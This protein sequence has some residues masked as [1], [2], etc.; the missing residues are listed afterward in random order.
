MESVTR[1]AL[2]GQR[3]WQGK[4][5]ITTHMW[6]KWFVKLTRVPVEVRP[7]FKTYPIIIQQ[8]RPNITAIFF[9]LVSANTKSLWEEGCAYLGWIFYMSKFYEIVDTMIILARGKKSSTLQTYHHA[10][11]LL[12]GWASLKY[13]SPAVLVGI[14]LNSGVH[15]LM[16][17]C[18]THCSACTSM[19]TVLYY[20]L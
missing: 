1:W 12:C 16:V 11:V 14:V 20:E 10:G 6:R 9:C 18:P 5:Q 8:T 19:L 17:Y 13:E 15:T 2:V 4:H 7:A 3:E